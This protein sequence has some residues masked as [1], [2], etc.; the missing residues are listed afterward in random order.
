VTLALQP[1]LLVEAPAGRHFAQF[2]R[3]H[4]DLVESVF[5]FLEAGLRRDCSVLI[6]AGAPSVD[7]LLERLNTGKF[8]YKSLSVS[9]QLAVLD[10]S[11]LLEQLG[12][13][14]GGTPAVEFQRAVVPVLSRLQPF[15]RGVRVYSEIATTLWQNGDTELAVQIEEAWNTIAGQQSFSLYCGFH[16]NIQSENSYT[17]PLEEL[18][19]THS[20]I[21]GGA[22]DERFGVALDRAS[23]EIFGISLTQMAGVTRQDGARK[24]PSG[25]RAML[26]VSRNL[27]MSTAQLA[28]RARQYFE[29]SPP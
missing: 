21:L 28:E 4:E 2:H 19:R 12:D 9:G 20:D 15:G 29:E 25:L 5:A 10:T 16:L 6:I 18:G 26:W 1:S 13:G 14:G 8:H 11:A 7:R 24:F 22:D 23:K 27:P 17:A 3:D